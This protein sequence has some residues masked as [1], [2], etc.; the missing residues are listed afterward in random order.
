[1]KLHMKRGG[2]DRVR[3]IGSKLA[4]HQRSGWVAEGQRSES[5]AWGIGKERGKGHKDWVRTGN[6]G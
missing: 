1:V 2:S 3:F 6:I 4:I 5:E